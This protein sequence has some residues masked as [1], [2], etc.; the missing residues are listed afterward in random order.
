MK[1]DA[2]T[3]LIVDD[4]PRLRKIFGAWFEREG[5]R[6]M[7]A[8]NGA[9]GLTLAQQD[10]VDLVISDI[11]M[12][13][14]DGIE[15]AHRLNQGRGYLPKMLFIS[16][17]GDI[18]DRDSYDIGIIQKLQKPIR[19]QELIE[20]ARRA[21]IDKRER[22]S[23][24]LR[25]EEAPVAA[26]VVDGAPESPTDRAVAFG[27]GGLCLRTDM[28]LREGSVVALSFPAL[29]GGPTSIV[30][31]LRWVAP[32][33]KLAGFEIRAVAPEVLEVVVAATEAPGGISYIPR[34]PAGG[35]G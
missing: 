12:P 18:A 1:L 13:V 7:L 32:Q 19:R 26:L 35:T 22:W 5:C 6:V 31:I 21:L 20:V 9:E 25:P 11:R 34:T 10:H 4:E 29:S 16:G 8:G 28:P 17:F 23:M 33:E 30:A 24:P 27:R 3:I 14:M 15:M 2:A